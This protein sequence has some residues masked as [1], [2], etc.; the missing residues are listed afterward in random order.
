MMPNLLRPNLLDVVL[1][2]CRYQARSPLFLIV[3]AT[4]FVMAFLGMASDSVQI[5]GS[6]AAL[7]LNSVFAIV[8]THLVF[9]I[10]GMFPAIA[11]VATSITRDH[12]LRTAEV[13]Y[14]SGISAAAFA[15]GRF[16]GGFLFAFG[17]GLA[18]LAGTLTGTFMPWLDPERIG[19]FNP[20]VWMFTALVILLPNYFFISSAFF[21]VAALTRSMAAAYGAAMAFMVGYITLSAFTGPEDLSWAIYVD[22]FG[23]AAIG[24]AFRYATVAER[25]GLLPTGSILTNRLIWIGVGALFLIIA[26]TRF[27]FVLKKP[28]RKKQAAQA[29]SAEKGPIIRPRT[30]IEPSAFAQ[31]GSQLRMDIRGVLRSAPFYVVLAMGVFNVIGVIY[32]STSQPYNTDSWPVTGLVLR[33]IE[34]GFLFFLLVIVVYYA[35]ELVYRERAARVADLLDATPS[36]GGAMILAKVVALWTIIALLLGVVMVTGM[37]I[38]LTGGFTDVEPLLYL[39]GLF[40]VSGSFFA[41]LAILAVAISV[42]AGNRWTGML[43]MIVVFLGT[44]ALSSF[45]FE[46][47]LYLFSVPDVIYSDMNGYGHFIEPL[48]W[49]TLYWAFF[50]VLL[51]IGAHLLHRRGY[52]FSSGEQLAIAR[53]RWTRG[54]G[55]TTTAAVAGMLLTGGWIVY[56]TTVLNAYET[57][58]SLEALQADYEKRYKS[59]EDLRSLDVV[60]VDAGIHLDPGNRELLS[61]GTARLANLTGHPV[62]ELVINLN[63]LLDVQTLD[64][65]GASRIEEDIRLGHYRFRFE[66]PVAPGA[67]STLTWKLYWNNPGFV[68]A[69][70]NNRIVANGTFV[71]STEVMPVTGYNPNRE[72]KDNNKRREHGLGPVERMPKLGDPAWFGVS[73]FGV[74]SRSNFRITVSTADDQIAIAPGYLKK[75]WTEDGRRF[76]SYEMDQP[77]WP[78]FSFSSARYAVARDRW[79]DVDITV[80]HEPKH[81]FNIPTM[82]RSTRASLD[83][84]TREFSPYQYRQFR[85]LEFPGYATFAQSFPNTIPFSEAI[86]FIS[87]ITDPG[88]IDLPFYV[89][90]HEMAHQWWGHQVAGANMQG[91]TVIVETLAQYSA[92]MVMEKTFGEA[93]MRRFIRFE[94]DNYLASRGGEL[95]EELPLLLTE[96]QPYLHYRKGSVAMYAL[97]QTIGEEAVNRA[98][99][100]FLAK[101]AFQ[102]PPFP[103]TRDL[104]GFFRA[105]TPPQYQ[106][107]FTDLFEKITLHELRV[108]DAKLDGPV[109]RLTIAAKKRYADGKGSETEVPMEEWVDIALLPEPEGELPENV[110]PTPLH[111]QRYRLVSGTN[112]VDIPFTGK[113]V[114]VAIDPGSRFIDRNPDDNL[115]ALE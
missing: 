5:G 105:E 17:V 112:S 12:E 90:A 26:I 2:E 71:D 89:T 33:A 6:D 108:V 87:N 84:F 19:D 109:A 25:N 15:S 3:A 82:L 45:G 27:R 95:I 69:R 55:L 43:A 102:P 81:P 67:G 104:F 22:P 52:V 30:R 9:S 107:W 75:E 13:F 103:T 48:V 63:T 96:D 23:G 39:R 46:H 35:G 74:S 85:I 49:Y 36:P 53:Q 61:S 31:F 40:L 21:C 110:L 97:R 93:A 77:I 60:D 99:R 20:G 101:F 54:I 106:D 72:L 57:E 4:F 1:F 73:Q 64:V 94:L 18:G 24:E 100:N 56:N 59:L 37:V 92:L 32:G 58:D 42:F 80:Y 91:Q 111:Q 78:F 16:L 70:P 44:S 38:Q 50:C 34:G 47:H 68:N 66:T 76:F 79:N 10:I 51:L 29:A 28:V 62:Q 115:K 88:S 11:F 86:G 65:T 7:D 83:Y 41:L 113:P 14:A 114:R 98:L 8:Q